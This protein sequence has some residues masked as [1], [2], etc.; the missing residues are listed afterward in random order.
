MAASRRSPTVRHRRLIAELSRLREASGKS[1]QEV[2]DLVGTTDVT[3]WRHET[4]LSRPSPA[5]VAALLE[6]Y[7]VVG[8]AR[9]ELLEMAREARK[10]G[11]WHPFPPHAQA[12][13]RLLHRAGGRGLGPAHLPSPGRSRSAPDQGV[14]P[15]GHR[16][17]DHDRRRAQGGAG[18]GARGRESGLVHA[19]G[20]GDGL[21]AGRGGRTGRL[22][23]AQAG[24]AHPPG[25]SDPAG[26][27]CST[28]R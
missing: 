19:G 27:P 23:H 4:G 10:R 11:W 2:A 18:D 5:D 17:H 3:L 7:G 12:G 25:R 22:P 8:D 6:I 9:G 15:G 24:A 13:V 1:R 20:G 26:P 28:R 14:R 16:G 21:R